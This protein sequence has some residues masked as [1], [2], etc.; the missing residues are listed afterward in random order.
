MDSILG[1]RGMYKFL[2]AFGV[3]LAFSLVLMP[4]LIPYLHKLKFGQAIR[5][6][7]PQSHLAKKGT[8]TMGGIGFVVSSVLAML[9]LNI[10][11]FTNI[12]F[13]I[14]LLAF[15]GYGLIG[16]IDDFI[17]V[18]KKDNEGLKPK[19]KLLLQS[20][21]AIVFYLLY[22]NFAESTV[23]IP[24]FNITID[25]GWLYFGLVFIMFTAETN[26][27]NFADGLDG[28]CA[29][30]VV[31]ALAPFILF[32]IIQ[33]QSDIAMFLLAL[34]GALLGYLKYNMHPAK[35]MM[36][37]T[38]SLA[39][40]GILAASAMVLK[41]ELA[42]VI[43]GGVFVAEMLSVVIQVGYFK[44]TKGKRFFKM[45]PI[46]HHFELSGYK[47]TQVVMM[48][49]FAGFVLSVIGILMGVLM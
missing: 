35:V 41:Q 45:A 2:L 18:V 13:V 8:P 30:L 39:L 1:G 48:F 49:W 19:Y 16:F 14:V 34:T 17:I 7:G 6:D 36:G 3:G 37:D 20:I 25:L 43:I 5:Q 46:H 24:F 47:E 28:L 12:N 31:M 33:K 26:A 44:L 27:V 32:A 23:L 15:L 21:L 9:V 42:L 10:K 40:G 4:I 38:G 22:R 11:A 29:G